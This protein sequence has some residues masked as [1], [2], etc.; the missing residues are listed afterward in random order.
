MSWRLN[1]LL[2]S[3]T[4]DIYLTEEPKFPTSPSVSTSL[5]S[6]GLT[7]RVTE[8]SN[9][10]VKVSF[11]GIC[12]SLTG[13][14]NLTKF[15]SNHYD[16][17]LDYDNVYLIKDL[18]RK[19]KVGLI[20]IN[21]NDENKTNT[22]SFS[23]DVFLNSMSS[24]SYNQTIKSGTA[25]TSPTSI[26]SISQSGDKNS[27]FDSM[28]FTGIY[29]GGSNL[30]SLSLYDAI[31]GYTLNIVDVLFDTATYTFYNDFTA[32][33][34]YED[35]FV[36]DVLFTRNKFSSSDVT[37][38]TDHLVFANSS[39]LIYKFELTHPLLQDPELVLS[40]T[41]LVSDPVIE[42]S[43]DNVT[44]WEIGKSL[45]SGESSYPLDNLAGY[46]TFYIKISC[47]SGDS[48]NLSNLKIMS[49]H[50]YTGQKPILYIDT[51]GIDKDLTLSFSGG[52]VEYDIRYSDYYTF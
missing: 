24:K 45:T 26:T 50:D 32:Y 11:S 13:L 23:M 27:Y 35:H 46:S 22:Y 33:H 41:S 47:D 14:R 20:S 42:V 1:D 40:V 29:N 6:D 37:F 3:Q 4:N 7:S 25:T 30:T 36:S 34:E 19:W 44:Y 49:W 2:L 31:L 5:N 52:N 17:T 9:G 51:S 38:D 12:T 28:E 16:W 10:V 39:Y 18:S 48:F 15:D 8:Y 43:P 21:V